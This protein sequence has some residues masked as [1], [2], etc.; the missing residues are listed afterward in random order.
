MTQNLEWKVPRI[1]VKPMKY[2]E[3]LMINSNMVP[4]NDVDL[5]TDGYL[6]SKVDYGNAEPTKLPFLVNDWVE[7]EYVDTNFRPC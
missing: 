6:I 1:T 3:Y 7:K 2:G 4:R 5:N